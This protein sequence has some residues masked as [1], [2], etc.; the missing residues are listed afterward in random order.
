MD[1][2]S[3]S[4]TDVAP[5]SSELSTPVSAS[6]KRSAHGL[7]LLSNGAVSMRALER[8][9]SEP[10]KTRDEVAEKL[11]E[12]KLSVSKAYTLFSL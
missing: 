6:R 10:T 4:E 12:A 1:T 9:K 5:D 8:T 7:E 3:D 11:F 2:S